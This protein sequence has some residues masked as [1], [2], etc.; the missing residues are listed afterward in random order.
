MMTRLNGI[1]LGWFLTGIVQC[2]E[3][4]DDEAL[5]AHGSTGR[6]SKTSSLATCCVNSHDSCRHEKLDVHGMSGNTT[7]SSA[8]S[9]R[10]LL[11]RWCRR[12]CATAR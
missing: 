2:R 1:N 5:A 10:P 9:V 4:V 12:E 11:G 7:G 3:R 8:S 6:T